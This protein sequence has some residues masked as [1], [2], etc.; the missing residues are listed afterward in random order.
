MTATVTHPHPEHTHTYAL[1]HIHMHSHIH[2]LSP[3]RDIVILRLVKAKNRFPQ[4][5]LKD[6]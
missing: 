3:P 4:T 5:C 6:I 2:L 1:T